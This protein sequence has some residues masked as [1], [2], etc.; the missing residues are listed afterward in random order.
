MCLDNLRY[1]GRSLTVLWDETGTKYGKGKGLR[2]FADGQQ[3]AV[4]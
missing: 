3:I 4:A 1:H 2:V